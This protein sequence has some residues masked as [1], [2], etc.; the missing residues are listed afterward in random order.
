M[1]VDE[2]SIMLWETGYNT[3]NC[4]SNLQEPISEWKNWENFRNVFSII[5]LKC[6]MQILVLIV[7]TTVWEIWNIFQVPFK[8]STIAFECQSDF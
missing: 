8:I 1:Y 4:Y 2:S 6:H 5:Y 3:K 7:H